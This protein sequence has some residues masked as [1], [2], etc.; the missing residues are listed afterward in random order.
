MPLKNYR[1]WRLCSRAYLLFTRSRH[2]GR[3]SRSFGIRGP[4]PLQPGVMALT[5]S[6]EAYY[7]P[8]DE[9][10]RGHWKRWKQTLSKPTLSA[11]RHDTGRLMASYCPAQ[12]K[13]WVGLALALPRLNLFLDWTPRSWLREAGEHVGQACQACA[14]AGWQPGAIEMATQSRAGRR[15]DRKARDAT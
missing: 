11:V 2:D 6:R 13:A 9:R 5:W 7:M 3:T 12:T 4:L 10:R 14:D 15:Q 1:Y 8:C